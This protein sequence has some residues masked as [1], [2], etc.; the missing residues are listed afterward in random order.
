MK[1]L[2]AVFVLAA[3]SI[4]PAQGNILAVAWTGAASL[5]DSTT[6]ISTPLGA[7]GAGGRT[8][9]AYNPVNGLFYTV[10]GLAT[11]T[12]ASTLYTVN[13][14]TGA[15]SS[16]GVVLTVSDVRA[17]AFSPA[18]ICYAIINATPDMLY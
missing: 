17:L 6:G 5:I 9:L 1:T 18:G 14:N 7:T 2:T 4:L 15:A 12:N 10:G 16:T 8:S 13:P 3:A 11:S